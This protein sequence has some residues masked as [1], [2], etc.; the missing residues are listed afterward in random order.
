MDLAPLVM[1]YKLYAPIRNE[2]AFSKVVV[3]EDGETL[4]WEDGAI[5]MP[6]T[7][8]EDLA[9]EQ[10][11]G[12]EFTL[13]LERNCLTRQAAAAE[14]GRSLRA[15][16]SYVTYKEPIPRVVALACKGFEARKRGPL[17]LATFQPHCEWEV[18]AQAA[19]QPA[20]DCYPVLGSYQKVTW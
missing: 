14:L 8:V 3:G 18:S 11:T 7:H 15:I 9:Q 1:Q 17:L 20:N 12:E 16:Q 4:E 2:D 5:D 6:A 10:M 19:E 13:F